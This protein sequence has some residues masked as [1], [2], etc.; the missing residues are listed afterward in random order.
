MLLFGLQTF[1]FDVY[2]WTTD[3]SAVKKLHEN[4]I[5]GVEFNQNA[6]LNYT[7]ELT[8]Y[9]VQQG[10]LLNKIPLSAIL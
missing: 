1:Y 10:Q 4:Y 5:H 6:C 2:I 3:L 9:R 7:S 8:R